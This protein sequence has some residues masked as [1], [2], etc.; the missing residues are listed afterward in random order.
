[1]GIFLYLLFKAKYTANV[2]KIYVG[3]TCFSTK[4]WGHYFDIVLIYFL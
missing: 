1:M 2:D 3:E 4:T